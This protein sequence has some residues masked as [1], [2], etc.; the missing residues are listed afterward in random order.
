MPM[1]KRA[2]RRVALLFVIVIAL[3]GAAAAAL[4]WRQASRAQSAAE[5]RAEGLEL[6]N[7]GEWEPA[8]RRLNDMGPRLREDAEAMAALADARRRVPLESGQHVVSAIAY[9]KQALVNEP[10]NTLALETL[11]DL[12]AQANQITELIDV[13]GRLL[14]QD[15]EHREALW[16]R[17]RGL[18]ALGRD[19]ADEAVDVF[20]ET[21]PDDVRGHALRIQEMLT[22]GASAED[23]R[24]YAD[25]QAEQR[26][27]S[28]EFLLLQAEA[29]VRTSAP[30][31][32]LQDLAPAAERVADLE[33][34]D[35]ASLARVVQLLD[36]LGRPQKA[37]ELLA[38]ELASAGEG[39][40]QS[41][42]AIA[43]ERDWKAGRVEQAR[44]RALAASEDTESASD[45]VLGWTVL[46]ADS[47]R[48]RAAGEALR[49][50][51]TH[52]ARFWTH[53]IDGREAIESGDWGAARASLTAALNSP[54]ARAGSVAPV[55][56]AEYLLGRAQLALG[57]WREAASRWERVATRNPGWTGVRLELSTLLLENGSAREA[58]DQAGQVLSR[59]P[60]NYGAG[61]AA[62][63][64]MVVMLETGRAGQEDS[65]ETVALVQELLKATEGERGAE[66]AQALA[67]EARTRLVRGELD[68]AQRAVD[69]LAELDAAAPAED[70]VPLL[71]AAEEAGL[72]GLSE[73]TSSG[74]GPPPPGV[75][76]REARKIAALGRTDEAR[77]LFREAI[78]S[79]PAA[80]RGAYRR[81]L[82]VW[83]ESEGEPDGLEMLVEI[84]ENNPR[85]A[86]AQLDLLN[87]AG[88]WSREPL[89]SAAV[90]RLREV[91]GETS[92]AWRIYEARRLLTFEPSEARAAQAI[93]LLGPALRA[94]APDAAALALAGEAM[95]AL[96]D[97]PAAA[98]YYGRAIDADARRA[99]LYPRLI[100]LLLG[101]GRL[102]LARARQR[103]FLEAQAGEGLTR[104]RAELSEALGMWEAAAADRGALARADDATPLDRALHAAAL[105]R[106]E[107]VAEADRVIESLAEGRLERA[108]AVNIVA[109]YLA[110]RG[111]TDRALE[112]IER[113]SL[114]AAERAGAAAGLL[115]R[116]GEPGRAA[117]VLS[118]AIEEE[119]SAALYAALA[120]VRLREGEDAS[121]REAIER[122]L[123]LDPESAELGT[124]SAAM[125]LRSGEADAGQALARLADIVESGDADPALAAVVDATRAYAEDR[126]LDAYLGALESA[127]DRQPGSVLIVR[128]LVSA[129]LQ[130]GD[131]EGAV[132]A[133]SDLARVM[134][135]NPEAAKLAA[136]TLAVTGRLTESESMARRWLELASDELPPREAIAQLCLRQGR[137]DDAL[138]ALEPVLDRVESA[139]AERPDLVQLLATA[140]AATGD[141][142]AARAL[143]EGRPENAD[144]VT[145]EIAAARSLDDE[146][147]V[148]RD[149]FASLGAS[150]RDLGTEGQAVAAPQL[151]Q[152][153]LDL[154]GD[155]GE[156]ADF[157]QVVETLAPVPGVADT[158]A[159]V[160]EAV[161]LEQ[162]GRTEEAEAKYRRG[163]EIMPGQPIVLN[164]LAYLLT[165]RGGAEEEAVGL[166]TQAVEAARQL[167]MGP[168]ERS[169]FLH[170]LGE[171]LAA[172]GEAERAEEIY[173]EAL[174]LTPLAPT[175]QL[176]LAELLADQGRV[177]EAKRALDRVDPAAGTTGTDLDFTER[178]DSLKARLAAADAGS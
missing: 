101:D 171:A 95:A 100:G 133:A 74:D 154:A 64:A 131:A 6:H 106:A 12:H 150:V 138:R 159:V 31:R 160:L 33:I 15:P 145:R 78:E 107:R 75:V 148:A 167:G 32:A 146:P 153:W 38:R 67:L 137:P 122:G 111:E 83:L 149:W 77:T 93:D 19:G 3:A 11:L 52:E 4:Q 112:V 47:D 29:R 99:G 53:L 37:D 28:A 102:E 58:F 50:R 142:A 16:A 165:K 151:A 20:V 25:A 123:E 113:S 117:E 157:E 94:A 9:A 87:S 17:A 80:E 124:L 43:V 143:F 39:A 110:A 18:I 69:R 41:V 134:G 86:G 136:E 10:G 82:A 156:A 7:R 49:L 177:E 56:V 60:G 76:A 54:A 57:A 147:G 23:V 79:A 89:V 66:H 170:T 35:P 68:L 73:L 97:A 103:E 24:A 121:A 115:A 132:A 120:R 65:D 61:K 91:G 173:R 128:L 144:W 174:E 62:A 119:P 152:A 162:L 114:G 109:D 168:A 85:V 30:G 96:G 44:S 92:T 72:R 5:A 40:D 45:A 81:A 178:Y 22:T 70:L 135:S 129:R 116:R 163:L 48:A 46:L 13:A 164:N 84:A 63:R 34:E 140:H 104:R 141:A 105:A 59:D 2:K 161:A 139:A 98:D 21:H 71:D 176:S 158:P 172:S 166:A 108:R 88:A 90:A 125:Q 42:I 27:R 8:L 26:P 127:R 175:V 126:D 130:A 169:G 155:T 55:D 118:R 51:G 14:G 1:T 36:M